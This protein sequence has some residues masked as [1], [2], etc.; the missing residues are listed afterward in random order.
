MSDIVIPLKI[1]FYDWCVQSGVLLPD[2]VFPNP[3]PETQWRDWVYSLINMNTNTL[4][5]LPIPSKIVYPEDKDWRQWAAFF[6]Q[7]VSLI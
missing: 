6:V 4:G 1:D 3:V 5:N 2:L 7:Y